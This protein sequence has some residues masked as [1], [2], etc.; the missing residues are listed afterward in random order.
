[1]FRLEMLVL[2]VWLVRLVQLVLAA[3]EA[4]PR[5]VAALRV[6]PSQAV[7]LAPVVLRWLLPPA[8][9]LPVARPMLQQAEPRAKASRW[10]VAAAVVG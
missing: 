2:A 1:M 4:R 5:L 9:V 10:K 3:Q 8:V 7:R 6:R